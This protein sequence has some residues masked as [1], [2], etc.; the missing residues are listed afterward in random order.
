MLSWRKKNYFNMKYVNLVISY[1]VSFRFYDLQILNLNFK[2]GFL[3][4]QSSFSAT[5]LITIGIISHNDQ[6]TKKSV[7]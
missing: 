1:D 5:I 2:D 6:Q 3:L 4:D 7:R